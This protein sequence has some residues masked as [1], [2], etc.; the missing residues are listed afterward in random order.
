MHVSSFYLSACETVMRMRKEEHS[1]SSEFAKRLID[2]MDGLGDEIRIRQILSE[3]VDS[4]TFSFDWQKQRAMEQDMKRIQRFMYWLGDV[5]IAER[6]RKCSFRCDTALPDGSFDLDAT[7]HLIAQSQSGKYLAVIVRNKAADKSIGGKSVHTAVNTDLAAMVAK[8]CLEKE[9]PGIVINV[10]YLKNES[11]S[12]TELLPEFLISQM[13]KSNVFSLTYSDFYDEGM[14][15]TDTFAEL[16]NRVV[17]EPLKKNCFGCRYSSECKVQSIAPHLS[18]KKKEERSYVMPDFSADQKSVIFHTDGPMRVCAGPGSGK[19]ATLVGRVKRLIS[20]GVPAQTILLITFTNEA[21]NE[22]LVR[23]EPFCNGDLPK[24]CTLNALGYEILRKNLDALGRESVPLL[25]DV[26]KIKIVKNLLSIY[27]ALTGFRSEETDGRNGLYR[28]VSR[29]LDEWRVKVSVEAFYQKNPRIG[30]DFANLA[31]TYEGILSARGFITYDEQISLTNQLFCDHPE[32]LRSYQSAFRYTMVDEFQDVNREQWDMVKA[33]ARENLVVV[34]DDDQALYGFRGAD[35]RFMISFNEFYPDAKT[36]VLRDNYRSSAEIVNTANRV[37]ERNRKR[38]KK[39]VRGTKEAGAKPQI[40]QGTKPSD[41]DQV[42]KSLI[43]SGYTLGDIA[44]LS[45]KNAPLEELNREMQTKTVLAKQI[46]RAQPFFGIIHAALSL[47]RTGGMSGQS[48]FQRFLLL[49]GV[50]EI[51]PYDFAVKRYADPFKD[52]VYFSGAREGD[53]LYM[54]LHALS[55]ALF[56]LSQ[57]ASPELFVFSMAYYYGLEDSAVKKAFSQLIE[58]R[59]LSTIDEF[60]KYLDYMVKFEDDT[61]VEEE[62]SDAVTLI[63]CHESKGK[64][65]P[66]VLIKD[67]YVNKTEETRRVF[68]VALTRAKERVVVLTDRADGFVKELSA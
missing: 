47:H 10:V 26:E 64:E 2:I 60:A 48:A 61:R 46:L 23:C 39:E 27:P 34:G 44:I 68:Y 56:F 43:N 7:V 25:T 1:H 63:T 21:A 12:D 53:L 22:L 67:D 17:K 40:F 31:E 62:R 59:R 32:V 16:I 45:T 66:V 8:F 5:K 3:V 18:A 51:V 38:I 29:K 50:R 54:A 37:I 58:E 52:F 36:V 49:N 4:S 55:Q 14:F 30:S 19:T 9:Y 15:E 6:N 24:I 57:N 20:D 65:Y 28:T 42:V 13:K 11:D 35:S 41:F 33:I